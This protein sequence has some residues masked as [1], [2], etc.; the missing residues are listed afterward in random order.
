[1]PP[2]PIDPLLPR[3]VDAVASHGA[4]VLVA[5]PGA[6]KTTRVPRELLASGVV[7]G[8]IL[9][10]QPRRLA[11]RLA[12]GWVA[13]EM[14]ERVGGVVGYQVR[15]ED[16]TGPE[17]R[18]RFITEALLL[19]RMLSSP[20]LDGV[21][22]VVFDEFH[23]RH[24]YADVALTLVRELQRSARPDVKIMVMSATM[25]AGPI[26]TY[27][28]CETLTSEG[29]RFDVDIE[30]TKMPDD[31]PLA[32]QVASAVSRLLR[33]GL[34][35]DV[36]TFLPGAAEIRRAAEA[37]APLAEKHELAVMPL[38]GDLPPEQQDAAIR[39]TGKRKVILS[40]N[41]AETSVTIDG[42]VAVIDSG[43]ARIPGHDP[44][45]GLPTLQVRAVSRASAAQRAGRAGRT[46]PGRCL[47]LYTQ[48]DHD[49][50]RQQEKPEVERLDLAE[51]AL[52][53]ATLAQD[54]ATLP[55]LDP[56]PAAALEASRDLLV[57][58]GALADDGTVTD[59]G[60]RMAALPLHP[61]QARVVLEA[62]RR[63]CLRAGCTVAALM[64]ERDVRR[65]REASESGPSDLLALADLISVVE[66]AHFREREARS[67]G[68]NL[69]AA[70]RVTSAR[71]QLMRLRRGKRDR[72]EDCD[73][74][75]Q[76]AI[77]AGYPDRVA[78]RRTPGEP[79]LLLALG[80][81]ARL[82]RESVVRDGD[83]MVA[84]AAEKRERSGG[85]PWVRLASGIEADWLLD[86]FPD[87]VHDSDELV[88]N[89]RGKRVERISR[90]AYELL[91]IDESRRHDVDLE[92]AA[93]LLREHALAAGPETFADPEALREL[94]ARADFVGE[95]AGDSVPSFDPEAVLA[96]MC[97]G[98]SSFAELHDADLLAQ[99]R[100]LLGGVGRLAP[101]RVT[102]P[103][104]RR[105]HV[106]Y[107][108]DRPP[109]VE[110]YL[111]DFF[112]MRAGPKLVDCRVPVTL[113]LLAP[114]R[115]AVQVT[116]D[117]ESFWSTH[118]P[119]LRRSLSRRYPKHDW[120][121]D[122]IT[123]K[124]PAPRKGGRKRRR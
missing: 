45:S 104:G 28:D 117:L 110:S 118:Y 11:A 31:R 41:V 101:E 108:V 75:L 81:S 29:R 67:L 113:H 68:I 23:E 6:G 85:A 18:L 98:R 36:L 84:V 92:R 5:P 103:G 1:M 55:W 50:R 112:G 90:V 63:G 91:V 51:T 8:E 20:E 27:L 115:R 7:D 100:A 14:G 77:L 87:A 78:R 76:I 57:R 49:T 83:W 33:E 58:L 21:G 123:A 53:L 79:E 62:E 38:Y 88:W 56:P 37:C 13:A 99:L 97:L 70:R 16:R 60:R 10:L 82:S 22:A 3:V 26:A 71:D 46:R 52:L 86:L 9:V 96:D 102:L 64:S 17:T 73:Q 42:V 59:E 69:G 12:A 124:P 72:V 54:P 66:K 80:G 2:L 116:T 47:R 65:N 24:I 93:V 4:L 61:R 111:Q 44:W 120:P 95:H 109:W 107:Q 48:H 121:D 25:D 32:T 114:N 39:P 15:F 119:D 34:D 35:G 106:H 94:R 40:T 74:P 122:P 19:R 89:D 105:L 30:Y 43:L